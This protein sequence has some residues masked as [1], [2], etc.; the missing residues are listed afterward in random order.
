MATH[1]STKTR[2]KEIQQKQQDKRDRLR[3]LNTTRRF[4]KN[5]A[6]LEDIKEMEKMLNMQSLL[7]IKEL[8]RTDRQKPS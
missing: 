6:T 7:K 5:Y 2:A 3:S 8:E 4:I 1:R